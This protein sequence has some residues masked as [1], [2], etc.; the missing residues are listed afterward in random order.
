VQ[1]I[2]QANADQVAVPDFGNLSFGQ[3][4]TLGLGR[5]KGFWHNSGGPL[6]QACDPQWRAAINT[7]FDGSGLPI[8]GPCL[9]R[10][11]SELVPALS[12]FN[13][14][15]LPVGFPVAFDQLANYLVGNPAH[16]HAGFI[17]STQVCAT[18][19]NLACGPLSEQSIVAINRFNDD[20]LF[21]L[22]DMIQQVR[23]AD[24]LC[25]P[26]AGKTM[27]GENEELRARLL[28]CVNEFEQINV[29]AGTT[30]TPSPN[31]GPFNSPY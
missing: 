15:L 1:Q 17:L 16:G 19:L 26:L 3:E 6:L 4:P 24:M 5:S 25:H 21:L 12:I 30:H 14:P 22:R 10:N 11:V 23:A 31:P 20:R 29:G 2:V 9:R 27:P 18:L 28:S 7:S 8:E 13:V